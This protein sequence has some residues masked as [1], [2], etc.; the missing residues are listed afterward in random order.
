MQFQEFAQSV[1]KAAVKRGLWQG[2]RTIQQIIAL[3]H[4]QWG[5]AYTEA[6]SG[7]PN[8]WHNC[9]EGDGVTN[10]PCETT[11]AY[12]CAYHSMGKTE[13]CPY[14]RKAA[15]GV[16]PLLMDGVM[17]I[18]DLLGY[19]GAQALDQDTGLSST[20]ESIV[21]I[22]AE[23]ATDDLAGTICLLH[24][25]TCD[26]IGYDDGEEDTPS[27][28]TMVEVIALATG[29]V[30]SQG[31]DPMALLLEKQIALLQDQA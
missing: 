9:T 21:D 2:D 6:Q 7:R 18:M 27:A 16:F 12:D 4:S 24:K 3:I 23:C 11:E 1:H 10:N 5:A 25:M 20:M 13:Q 14:R 17:T 30:K 29:W 15:Q 8:E 26:V 28:Q 22:G 31:E 19:M